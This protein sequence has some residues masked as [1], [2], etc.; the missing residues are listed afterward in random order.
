LRHTWHGSTNPAARIGTPP[1]KYCSWCLIVSRHRSSMAQSF[2][3]SAGTTQFGQRLDKAPDIEG[4]LLGIIMR[5]L[6]SSRDGDVTVALVEPTG[7]D[8]AMH[9]YEGEEV[10][11]KASHPGRSTGRGAVVQDPEHSTGVTRGRLRHYRGNKTMA[12]LAAD[13]WLAAA[14]ALPRMDIEQGGGR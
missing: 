10:G 7:V 14:K 1:D 11:L 13:G 5:W 3:C 9:G 12:R 4:S 2:D 8:R 6:G